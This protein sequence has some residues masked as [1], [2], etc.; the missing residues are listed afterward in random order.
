MRRANWISLIGIFVVAFGGLALTLVAGNSP[1]LGLDLQGGASVVLQPK[2]QVP[3]DVLDQTIS[4]IRNRVDALGVAEPDITRQGNSVLVQLPG[5]RDQQRALDLVGQTAELRFRP[6]LQPVPPDESTPVQTVPPVSTTVA[7]DTSTTVADATATSAP[8]TTVA[9]ATTA[10]P[11]GSGERGVPRQAPD[12]TAPPATTAEPTTTATTAAG[13]TAATTS[14]GITVP[15]TPRDDDV[16][17]QVVVLPQLDENGDVVSR[18]QLGPAALTGS[19]VSSARATFEQG[20]WLV[21]VEF[22]GDGIDAFN[23]LAA[24]CYQASDPTVCPSGQI[25]ITLDG[26]VQSAPT[27]QAPEFQRDQVQI[28]GSFDEQSAKDLALVLRYG[29][30]PVQLEP[31]TVQTVSATLGKDS[32]HAGIIAGLVGLLLV[33]AYMTLYYRWLGPVVLLGLMVSGSL[34]YTIIAFLGETQGL[35]LTL[36][37]VTGIIVSIGV[38]V[39]SYVVYFERLKDDV[40]SGKSM[41][42]SAERG[43][44]NAYRTILAADG[45]SLIGAVLLY[46]LTVGSVRGFAF[47]LGLATLLDMIVAYFYTR[48]MVILLSR[49][50]RF[51]GTHVMGVTSGEAAVSAGRAPVGAAR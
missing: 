40:R 16:A 19:G 32:L 5:V 7:G 26:E 37:G 11:V 9:P 31:Q 18:L 1:Q 23:A 10:P 41:R 15:T 42:S 30:L 24:Q 39:D 20:E 33:I 3:S 27:V 25:A 51:S 2:E 46:L 14:P 29:A 43:F 38:T 13:D 48:P 34:L 17:D 22:T 36:A 4:I 21:R 8:G 50:K 35:A 45:A 28:S 49:T 47:F 12:T 44:S 6:V